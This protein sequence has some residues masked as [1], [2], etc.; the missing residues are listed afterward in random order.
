MPVDSPMP[1]AILIV[2][3][4]PAIRHL[5]RAA[6]RHAGYVTLE[7]DSAGQAHSAIRSYTGK[8]QLAIVDL[9]MPGGSGLDLAN[10]LKVD[11]PGIPILYISGLI[12]SVAVAS[13]ARQ[14]PQAILTKP[15]TPD[16]L[17]ARVR[18]LLGQPA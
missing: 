11:L 9:L 15:F 18:G 12:H 5:T 8:I 16:Q 6:L 3:D 13:L 10:Q 14:Q 7:A 17:L 1:T 4:E 2:D